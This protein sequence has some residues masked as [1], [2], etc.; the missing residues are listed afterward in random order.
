M[1][2]IQSAILVFLFILPLT[3]P[4]A[5]ADQAFWDIRIQCTGVNY[6]EPVFQGSYMGLAIILDSANQKSIDGFNFLIGYDTAALTYIDGQLGERLE[7]WDYLTC[8]RLPQDSCNADC[9]TGLLRLAGVRDVSYGP[10]QPVGCD[11][12][13]GLFA[14]P[15]TEL[16]NLKFL[17]SSAR[18]IECSFVPVYFYWLDC[19][20]NTIISSSSDTIFISA[21]VHNLQVINKDIVITNLV[22]K[23]GTNESTGHRYGAF[24][25][26]NSEYVRGISF[27]NG[28]MNL[29]CTSPDVFTGNLD[30]NHAAFEPS[31][32]ILFVEYFIYG[33]SVF[34]IDTLVQWRATDINKD[35]VM[36]SVADLVYMI[37]I[38]SGDAKPITR[39]Y[40]LEDTAIIHLSGNV[41]KL[42]SDNRIGAICLAFNGLIV[43]GLLADSMDMKYDYINGKTR[44]LVCNLGHQ[45]IPAGSHD[46]L[47]FEYDAEIIQ[48]EASGYYGNRLVTIIEPSK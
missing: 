28:G 27:Y 41:V 39:L 6:W 22:P 44:I 46:I 2:L 11:G 33:N 23:D 13:D 47:R 25:N 45:F 5:E 36:A 10:S 34:K 18:E 37:R 48:A 12:E 40:H 20:D 7:C 8:R 16:V 9:P 14:R 29:V 21:D 32:A 35:S 1:R 17:V 4:T 42:D 31:D 19:K 3:V 15:R 26:C 30:L 24:N 38:I 43:P